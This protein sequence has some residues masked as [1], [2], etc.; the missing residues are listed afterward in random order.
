MYRFAHVF[1]CARRGVGKSAHTMLDVIAQNRCKVF[2]VFWI[3]TGLQTAKLL[4]QAVDS[5]V[6]V[7]FRENPVLWRWGKPALFS[8]PSFRFQ[9]RAFCLPNRARFIRLTA[10]A[11]LAFTV[12]AV[13]L[14]RI[15]W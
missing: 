6:F 10:F 2:Q 5:A 12:R 1:D 15:F 4:L 11:H 7:L 3:N 13:E 14:N 8:G 9:F